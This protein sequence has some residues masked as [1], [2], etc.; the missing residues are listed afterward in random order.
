MITLTG[1]VWDRVSQGLLRLLEKGAFLPGE[2]L[3]PPEELARQL[4]VNPVSVRRA[5]AQLTERGLL[6]C[7]EETGY[8]V[9][10]RREEA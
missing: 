2:A 4:V 8:F 7:R 3:P 5:Y 9:T 1:P 10:E 6:E